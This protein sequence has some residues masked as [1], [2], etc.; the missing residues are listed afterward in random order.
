MQLP[1]NNNES[2]L[3]LKRSFMSSG[4]AISHFKACMSSSS[5][6]H[7]TNILVSYYSQHDGPAMRYPRVLSGFLL[8]FPLMDLLPVFA[9]VYMR[10]SGANSTSLQ[11]HLHFLSGLP[12]SPI[13]GVWPKKLPSWVNKLL[14]V[15]SAQASQR[16]GPGKCILLRNIF[17]TA[18]FWRAASR[19]ANLL[20][21]VWFATFMLA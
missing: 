11:L 21:C 10:V 2:C 12:S 16:C 6:S 3:F 4:S 20:D 18:A 15:L 7:S 5:V 9:H 1:E 17:V 13:R 8:H 14:F 19:L